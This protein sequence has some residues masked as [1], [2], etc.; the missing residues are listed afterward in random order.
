METPVHET[1]VE[2]VGVVRTKW[3]SD[4][5]AAMWNTQALKLGHLV[6]R[7]SGVASSAGCFPRKA[8]KTLPVQ[9]IGTDRT[10]G[11]VL[12]EHGGSHLY[13]RCNTCQDSKESNM[14]NGVDSGSCE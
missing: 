2:L 6:G 4:G 12:V 7:W 13:E 11:V 1:H 8:W 5:H 10:V 3:H 9:S 14:S